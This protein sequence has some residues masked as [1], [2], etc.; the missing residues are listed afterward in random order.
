MLFNPW[1]WWCSKCI[2]LT[3]SLC[4]F[5][6][7]FISMPCFWQNREAFLVCL[8]VSVCVW[9]CPYA[10]SAV[11]D[12]WLWRD[13]P[14]QLGQSSFSDLPGTSFH[15]SSFSSMICSQHGY[16]RQRQR[17]LPITSS[18]TPRSQTGNAVGMSWTSE[19]VER[20]QKFTVVRAEWRSMVD[21]EHRVLGGQSHCPQSNG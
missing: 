9:C 15:V 18:F 16:H 14:R 3:L 1:S 8:C 5:P 6:V 17:H 10:V 19:F 20:E 7:V 13:T 11:R 12:Y 4:T 2:Q 21:G